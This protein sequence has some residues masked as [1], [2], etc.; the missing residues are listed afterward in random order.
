MQFKYYQHFAFAGYTIAAF[1][2]VASAISYIIGKGAA[3][4]SVDTWI[5]MVGFAVSAIVIDIALWCVFFGKDEKKPIGTDH[6]YKRPFRK[7][8]HKNHKKSLLG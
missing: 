2:F 1:S 7:H 6:P 4:I 5:L 8:F 3:N